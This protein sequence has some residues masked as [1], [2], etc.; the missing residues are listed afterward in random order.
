MHSLISKIIHS[1]LVPRSPTGTHK[2]LRAIYDAIVQIA[3]HPY[4][5]VRT[6]D[7]D[8][9]VKILGRYRY[10]IFYAVIGTDT[11]EIVHIR[12]SAR[13]PWRERK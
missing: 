6:S 12:H 2:V 8:I 7:P 3:E 11:I 1:Y 9:R 5:A 4:S 10:K 13:R